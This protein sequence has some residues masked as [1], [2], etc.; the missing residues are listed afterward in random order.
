MSYSSNRILLAGAALAVTAMVQA[1]AHA[2]GGMAMTWR[3]AELGKS[4]IAAQ[5]SA[6][7]ALPRNV[8]VVGC[9]NP[10][11]GGCNAYKGDTPITERRRIMCFVPGKSAEPAGYAAVFAGYPT[12]GGDPNWRSYYGWSGGQI[13]LSNYYLGSSLTSKAVA[14]KNCQTDLRDPNAR[15][16]EH[17]DNN[18]NGWSLGGTV[19]P[20]S[21]VKHELMINCEETSKHKYWASINGQP[22]NPWNP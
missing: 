16:I 10:N 13:G 19:H 21:Q 7:N 20:G 6:W 15:M 3:V 8:V 1:P 9:G 2:T 17:H 14:D 11:A 12:G 4:S 22:A 18:V 5:A